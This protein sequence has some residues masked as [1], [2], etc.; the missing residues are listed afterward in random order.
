MQHFLFGSFL[1]FVP[2]SLE[3]ADEEYLKQLEEKAAQLDHY[4]DPSNICCNIKVPSVF[5]I[6]ENRIPIP[7]D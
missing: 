5:G 4:H 1:N 7:L 6:Q 2:T 3:K